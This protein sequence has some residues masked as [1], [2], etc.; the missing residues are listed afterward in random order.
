MA[1]LPT[2][3]PPVLL[4]V[5]PNGARRLKRDHPAI[6]LTAAELE[7]DARR[8]RAAGA[9]LL[10]LHV[11]DEN[12]H[13]SLAPE[14]YRPAIT[15]IR[16]AVGDGMVVQI[17]TEA[18][19]R[20]SPAEQMAVVRAIVPEAASFAI[21]ELVPAADAEAAARNFFAWV[22]ETQIIPQFILYDVGDV[23]HLRDLIARGIV[24]F[25]RPPVLFVLGRYNNGPPSHPTMIHPFLDAW[26]DEGHWSVCAF[27]RAE[28]AVAAA[29]LALGGHC[30]T[31]FENNVQRPDG[32]LLSSNAEQVERIAGIAEALGRER[33]FCLPAS[34]GPAAAI[35]ERTACI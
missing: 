22:A 4:S 9:G 26:G 21:R 20:Y 13:H 34:Q 15:A 24:P 18:V 8:C 12:G 16:R 25:T 10:H 1:D 19:G 11:R 33:A 30:R 35:R 23:E 14:H 3:P 6:P 5:A 17:T 28:T 32:S 29:A 7:E 31:G 27:G 2:A